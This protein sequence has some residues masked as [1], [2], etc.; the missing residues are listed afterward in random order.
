MQAELEFVQQSEERTRAALEDQRSQTQNA[1]AMAAKY[2]ARTSE[3]EVLR[4]HLVYITL[5][6]VDFTIPVC[7]IACARRRDALTEAHCI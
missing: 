1:Q 4:S 3:L 7:G 2:L 6:L 5:M